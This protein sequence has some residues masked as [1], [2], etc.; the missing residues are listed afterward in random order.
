MH[1]AGQLLDADV[2]LYL[3][4]RNALLGIHDL[5]AVNYYILRFKYSSTGAIFYSRTDWMSSPT[6]W[7]PDGIRRYPWRWSVTG[8][9]TASK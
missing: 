1:V 6:I 7:R 2:D 5:S 4:R 9:I 3:N 8:M